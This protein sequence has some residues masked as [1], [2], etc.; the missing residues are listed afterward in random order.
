MPTIGD[1]ASYKPI[2][3]NKLFGDPPAAPV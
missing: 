3:T 2:I 1:L